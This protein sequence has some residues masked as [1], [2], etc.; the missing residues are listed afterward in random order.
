MKP[1][2]FALFFSQ[3]RLS[4]RMAVGLEDA[5]FEI[6]DMYT[7]HFK[8]QSQFKAF[9]MDHFIEKKDISREEK[10]KILYEI[11]GRKTAQ[12]KP[13]FETI[14]M[15]QKPKQGTLVE[16]WLKYETGL[17]DTRVVEYGNAPSTVM[18]FDKEKRSK[19]N[20]HPTVKP[21]NLIMFLIQTFS[22]KGQIVLDPFL[23]SGTTALACKYTHRSCI[24]FE[25]DQEYFDIIQKRFDQ[26]FGTD[27]F[28][29]NINS[30]SYM[31]KR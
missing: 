15:C 26:S 22:K 28:G 30:S 9:S 8:N 19:I 23:G 5:G 14:I 6:R 18:N 31:S 17:I 20:T 29:E 21:T 4:H 13:N 3:P 24:G 12:L 2:A 16:N 25:I 1:G 27:M 7:W 11:D 10:D